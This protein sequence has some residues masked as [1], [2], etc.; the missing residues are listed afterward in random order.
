MFPH[1]LMFHHFHDAAHP[2]GQGAISAEQFDRILDLYNG[3]IIAP[4]DWADRAVKGKLADTD[5]CL[6][7]DDALKCQVDVGVPVLE[8]RGLKAFWFV[9]S[10]VFE[11][12]IESLEVF[13]YFR[14]VGFGSF[15][16]F[17]DAFMRAAESRFGEKLDGGLK[18]IDIKT[19]LIEFPFYSY[20]DRLYRFVRD[21]VLSTGE[22]DQV[23]GDM[24][25]QSGFDVAAVRD[26][27]WMN[28]SH[29][30][31]L[32]RAGH[33]IGLHSYTHPIRIEE[34]SAQQQLIEY[35]NNHRH[36]FA[37]TGTAPTVVSHPCNS[38]N[39]DTIAILTDLGVGIGFCSNMAKGRAQT[40]LE[41]PREDHANI[42]R[43]SK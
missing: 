5:V 28:D 11:G 32:S 40:L 25:R 43:P 37:T 13:R 21:R 22:Y 42:I 38:Y 35:E 6:T 4:A 36:I 24:M 2:K 18:G 30:A 19:Y 26:K 29:L 9:Y 33:V 31:A 34:L 10:S 3:R 17:C 7:F 16:E 20:N 15:D 23:M 27:L 41:F 12:N 39:A 1:G 8:A 14:T